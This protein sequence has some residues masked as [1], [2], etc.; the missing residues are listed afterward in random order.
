MFGTDRHTDRYTIGQLSYDVGLSQVE[1]NR[2]TD[3]YI[4]NY[5]GN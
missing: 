5:V 4:D 3:R 1:T 2:Q